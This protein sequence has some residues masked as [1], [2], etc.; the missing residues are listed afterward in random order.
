M[1]ER[2]KA[3]SL[4]EAHNREEMHLK[5]ALAVEGALR[6]F[7][8]R[9]GEDVELWG[10]VGLLHDLDWEETPDRH[11]LEGARWLEEAGYAPEFVRAVQ[12]HA[13][14][15]TGVHPETLL[16]KT[17]YTVDELTGFVTAVAL[18][19]PSRSLQDLEVSS[20]KKKWKDK[21]FARGVNREV[22]ARGAEMLGEP[23]ETLIAETIAA[24]RPLEARIGLGA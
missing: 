10:L 24:L 4:L 14:E 16:E 9:A 17:L 3:W 5:H 6:H 21:A 13:W 1:T 11:G 23:L 18:V 22:I 15:M 12:A 7:A 8:A 2:D 19:R 20:V